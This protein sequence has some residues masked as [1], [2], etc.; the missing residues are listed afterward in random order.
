MKIGVTQIILGDMSLDDTLALCADAGYEAVELTFTAEG[1]DLNIDMS[2]DELSSVAGRCREAGVTIAAILGHYAE[3][4][5]LLSRDGAEREAC[6]RCLGRAL[7]IAGTLGTEAVLL[8][9]GQ[10]SAAGTYAQAWDDLV[11]GLR[12]L[13][14]VA[15][16]NQ[17][18]IAVE[19]VW[20]KFLLSPREAGQLV[21]EIGSEWV[22]IYLD[23]A[24][25]MAYGF[26][27]HWIRDL[28][29]RIKKVHLKD[30]VRRGSSWVDL[31]DGDTDWPTVMAE[32]R[33]I[34]YDGTL[35]HEVGGEH[36]KQVEMAERMRRIVAL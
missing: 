18:A 25:M 7:E 17:A 12:D 2:V 22:G 28:G 1:K 6:C 30:F 15:A 23:T 3:R 29:Q 14:P 4:G 11:G 13:A 36:G 26:P 16:Q 21:D 24:N 34:G 33:N 20:N 10:L 35:I 9:P 27:E 19:N 8:H 31:M 5:N 32:L